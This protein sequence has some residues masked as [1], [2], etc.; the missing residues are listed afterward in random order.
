MRHIGLYAYRLA[1]LRKIT[2]L[3]ATPLELC[4]KLEQLRA[5][6]NGFA[7]RVMAAS[8]TPGPDVNTPEDLQRAAHLIVP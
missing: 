7:I 4:E 5:L 6:E 8:V 2:A 3:P 1:A